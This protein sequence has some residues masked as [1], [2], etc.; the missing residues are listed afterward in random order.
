MPL[1]SIIMPTYNRAALLPDTIHSILNQ[2]FADF[3]LIVVDDGST[4]TTRAVVEGFEDPRIV[5]HHKQNEERA[6]ARNTGIRLASSQYIT[7][8]DS[9]DKLYKH[10]LS[11]AQKLISRYEPQ[12]FHLNY[13]ICDS[14]G[15]KLKEASIRKGNLGKQLVTGNHLSCLGVFVEREFLLQNLFDEDPRLIGSEDY[16]LWLRLAQQFELK[17]TN[18]VTAA[19][20]Q[21]EVRSVMGFPA[22]MLIARINYLI[23]K[24]EKISIFMPRERRIFQS[25]RYMYLALHLTMGGFRKLAVSY[26]RKSIAM[27]W[28]I[29]WSRKSAGFIK[30]LIKSL[31]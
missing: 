12:W 15:D 14:K 7:F 3:E 17:Y 19:I 22:D 29:V 11:K 16:D 2:E 30:V 25:H 26:F 6:I 28:P 27:Y 10:H 31:T 1:F 13:E 8:V 9:D 23:D 4:D 5:Y 24:E 18:E 21:H 20:V